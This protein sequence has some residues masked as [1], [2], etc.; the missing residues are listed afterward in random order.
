V[1]DSFPPVAWV[2]AKLLGVWPMVGDVIKSPSEKLL[3]KNQAKR[4]EL[5][6]IG[7]DTYEVKKGT[8]IGYLFSCMWCL[9]FW[10]AL[11]HV[12]AFWTWPL[13][14]LQVAS[15]FAVASIASFVYN[16]EK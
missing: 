11:A 3:L 16:Q 9:G 10:V 4:I 6:L 5:I 7:H 15:I 14:T 8:T 2:R 12:L 1:I 13:A